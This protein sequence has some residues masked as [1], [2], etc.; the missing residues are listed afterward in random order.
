M[1]A[2]ITDRPGGGVRV[3][4]TFT[5]HAERRLRKVELAS[6][7]MTEP[8]EFASVAQFEQP[9]PA[10][11]LVSPSERYAILAT[12]VRELRAAMREPGFIG[13]RLYGSDFDVQLS[14]DLLAPDVLATQAPLR[15]LPEVLRAGRRDLVVIHHDLRADGLEQGRNEVAVWLVAPTAAGLEGFTRFVA[16]SA[17]LQGLR[18]LA[19]EAID[20]PALHAAASRPD[21][22]REPA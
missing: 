4:G 18:G 17:F 16:G 10:P 15:L 7:P 14:A 20:A 22:V 5:G 1:N 3:S 6:I 8:H 13:V 21:L 9:Q 11:V 2:R 19:L 12:L